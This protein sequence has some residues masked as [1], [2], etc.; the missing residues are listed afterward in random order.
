MI[1]MPRRLI[2]WQHLTALGCMG[3]CCMPDY[4]HE[5]GQRKQNFGLLEEFVECMANTG[6]MSV[7]RSYQTGCMPAVLVLRVQHCDMLSDKYET[8]FH[9]AGYAIVGFA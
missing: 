3:A 4:R 5:L 2:F 6:Q 1:L 9:M 7:V 8:P